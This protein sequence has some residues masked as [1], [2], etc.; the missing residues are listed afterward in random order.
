[1]KLFSFEYLPIL[2]TPRLTLREIKPKDSV[3]MFEYAQLNEVTRYLLWREHSDEDQTRRCIKRMRQWY[4]NS[5]YYDWAIIYKGS[6]DDDEIM[7]SY[8]GRM[9]GTCGFASVDNE[10]KVGEIG[11]VL[12]PKLRGKEIIV[13]AA[14]AVMDFGF[15]ELCLNRIEAKYIIGNSASR[16]VMEKL[17]MQYEGTMRSYMLIKGMYRDIGMCAIL[18]SDRH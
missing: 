17:G 11:Y 16:R 12:N 4:R 1:M 13:E 7:R 3:D 18:R 9:I 5:E 14:R 15:D 6:E 10:N 8:R 2:E